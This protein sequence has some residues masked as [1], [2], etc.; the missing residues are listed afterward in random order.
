MEDMKVKDVRVI[1]SNTISFCYAQ[2]Q[3]V[4]DVYTICGRYLE[5]FHMLRAL[6]EKVEFDVEIMRHPMSECHDLALVA[7]IESDLLPSITAQ[8][9]DLKLRMRS[10]I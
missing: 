2:A 9:D 3:E 5:A 1:P 10:G 7:L 4:A 8:M 6:K